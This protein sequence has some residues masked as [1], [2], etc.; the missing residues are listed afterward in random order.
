MT[1]LQQALPALFQRA[2]WSDG[3]YLAFNGVWALVFC[4]AALAV[5]PTRPLPV[6]IVLFFAVAGG[7]GNGVLHL[8]LVLRQ[9]AYF[10]GAWTAP[11]CFVVGVWLLRLLYSPGQGS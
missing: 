7:V 3:Q 8:L 5:R 4:I 10:P 11:L 1:G 9:A 2:P 6:L